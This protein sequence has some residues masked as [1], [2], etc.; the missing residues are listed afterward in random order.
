MEKG[1]AAFIVVLVLAIAGIITYDMIQAQ[2][3]PAPATTTNSDK[4]STAQPVTIPATDPTVGPRLSQGTTPETVMREFS[5]ATSAIARETEAEAFQ[6]MYLPSGG[7]SGV[8]ESVIQTGTPSA[9]AYII[10]FSHPSSEA[11]GGVFFIEAPLAK[12]PPGLAKGDRVTY[13]GRIAKLELVAS[14]ISESYRILLDDVRVLQVL[15]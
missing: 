8:V 5:K 6:R 3:T 11:P 15:K 14:A 12:I 9:P 7:W 13:D 10:R 4:D 2:K 1:A